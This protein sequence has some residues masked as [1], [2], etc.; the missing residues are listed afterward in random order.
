[1]H[2]MIPRRLV[3]ALVFLLAL[4]GL[5]QARQLELHS[6]MGPGPGLFPS[7]V[8]GAVAVLALLL[9]LLPA[10]GGSEAGEEDEGPPD[11]R[12]FGATI[13]ALLFLVPAAAWLGF[14]AA[15]IGIALLMAWLGE[16]RRPWSAF[17]FG[18]GCAAVGVLFFGLAL[19]VDIPR[20]S[21]DES[22]QRIFR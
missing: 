11:R 13:A 7:I 14:T 8:L 19:N 15:A 3:P 21:F 12:A 4:I 20:S 6:F 18:L 5:G 10:L 22:V 2:P 9:C 16:G 17:A 1:M